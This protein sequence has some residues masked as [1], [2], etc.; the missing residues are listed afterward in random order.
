M[1]VLPKYAPSTHPL[2]RFVLNLSPGKMCI[3]GRVSPAALAAQSV[4]ICS[5]EFPIIEYTC[6]E[7]F[8]A[9]TFP[10]FGHRETPVSSAFQM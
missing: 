1:G 10:V 5:F 4:V 9:I 3:G 6:Q 8:K 2:I 7:C